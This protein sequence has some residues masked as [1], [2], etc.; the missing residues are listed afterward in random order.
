MTWNLLNVAVTVLNL[1]LI[2]VLVRRLIK[3]RAEFR[4]TRPRQHTRLSEGRF[5]ST[6]ERTTR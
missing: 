1:L 4:V 3:G 5:E 6:P 2:A